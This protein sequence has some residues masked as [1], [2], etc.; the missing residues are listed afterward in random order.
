MDYNSELNSA[1]Q[2]IAVARGGKQLTNTELALITGTLPRA[3][4]D[5]RL[6]DNI[7]DR[8]ANEFDKYRTTVKGGKT[9]IGAVNRAPTNNVSSG[10]EIKKGGA[11][12][13]L[14]KKRQGR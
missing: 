4:Q 14:L 1:K 13:Q 7:I 2:N 8:Y 3:M 10:I 5:P 12:E 6:W 9:T 11:M